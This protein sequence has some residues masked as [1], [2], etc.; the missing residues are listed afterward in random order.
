MSTYSS[1]NLDKSLV[2]DA[3]ELLEDELIT[4][5]PLHGG[6][7]SEVIRLSLRSGKDVVVKSGPYPDREGRMLSRLADAGAEVPL[8]IASNANV[9]V[10]EDLGD[11]A[12]PPTQ[13][14][15]IWVQT[16]GPSMPLKERDMAGTKTLPSGKCGFT[17]DGATSGRTSGLRSAWR[18]I[19]LR[20]LL[21]LRGDS[22]NL[23]SSY[24]RSCLTT[25]HRHFY[26]ATFGPVTCTSPQMAAHT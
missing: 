9:L 23:R 12:S 10:L 18:P 22:R 14:G 5:E 11:E 3:L 20:C 8:P 1:Q 16:C 24:A 2:R 15:M 19:S 13:P 17:M 26:M 6:D 25:R 7:L 21:T 4:W